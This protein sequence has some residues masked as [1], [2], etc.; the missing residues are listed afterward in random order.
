MLQPFFPNFVVVYTLSME[1]GPFRRLSVKSIC[2]STIQE[3]CQTGPNLNFKFPIFPRTANFGP[4]FDT[5]KASNASVAN[6]I[7]ISIDRYLSGE[8]QSVKTIEYFN[9]I[10]FFNFIIQ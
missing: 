4:K 5:K 1:N 3:K 10:F 6:L 8:Y 2:V 9:K 7:L